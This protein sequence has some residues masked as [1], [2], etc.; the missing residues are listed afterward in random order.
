MAVDYVPNDGYTEDAFIAG[1]NGVHGPLRFRFRRAL[2]WQNAEARRAAARL[3]PR[4]AEGHWA[5]FLKAQLVEWDLQTP[6]GKRVELTEANILRM[7]PALNEA[8][9]AVVMSVR[10]GDLDPERPESP[11]GTAPGDREGADAKN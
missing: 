6:D 7:N 8:V 5:K 9:L 4:Q 2:G 1:F 11:D 3:E 10:G